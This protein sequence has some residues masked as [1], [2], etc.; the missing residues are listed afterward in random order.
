MAA[1]LLAESE[2]AEMIAAAKK[3]KESRFKAERK[4]NAAIVAAQNAEARKRDTFARVDKAINSA[5][6]QLGATVLAVQRDIAAL[7]AADRNAHAWYKTKIAE[8]ENEKKQAK[9]ARAKAQ[10]AARLAISGTQAQIT[11]ANRLAAAAHKEEEDAKIA[12]G[13]AWQAREWACGN[14]TMAQSQLDATSGTLSAMQGELSTKEG[15][16]KAKQGEL[17]AA[18]GDLKW[19]LDT[20]ADVIHSRDDLDAANTQASSE[21]Q[22]AL[23]TLQNATMDLTAQKDKCD[24]AHRNLETQKAEHAAAVASGAAP[25]V[26]AKELNDVVVAQAEVDANSTALNQAVDK[27]D[28]ASAKVDAA[29]DKHD[30]TEHNI[31]LADVHQDAGAAE[32]A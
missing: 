7:Q 5:N 21:L 28:D 2:K 18:Y 13:E 25:E 9:Q 23:A 15:E 22:N 16:L 1:K 19:A 3:A 30:E 29:K 32:A 6:A 31:T 20:C 14:K 10:A 17:K 12:A 26:V 11:K 8:Y 4:R 24:A 27:K